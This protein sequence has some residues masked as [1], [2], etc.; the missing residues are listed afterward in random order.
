[1]NDEGVTGRGGCVAFGTLQH[2]GWIDRD[3]ALRVAQHGE[4]VGGGCCDGSLD[5]DAVR[6]G[7]ILS[8][9]TSV[10]G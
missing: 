2:P 1:M 9:S 4:D 7:P 10:S 3:M 5:L 8:R 6:L